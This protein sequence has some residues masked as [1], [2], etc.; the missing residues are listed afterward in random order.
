MMRISNGKVNATWTKRFIRIIKGTLEDKTTKIQLT[1]FL[2]SEI[3][4]QFFRLFN[5]LTFKGKYFLFIV[6]EKIYLNRSRS[7]NIHFI[8]KCLGF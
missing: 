5:N 6:S 8:Y 1:D 3:E 7:F 2:N 4:F